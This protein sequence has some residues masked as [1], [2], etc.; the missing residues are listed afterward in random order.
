MAAADQKKL[1]Q[2]TLS[3]PRGTSSPSKPAG[4]A[5]STLRIAPSEVALNP[6]DMFRRPESS[7]TESQ[8]ASFSLPQALEQSLAKQGTQ[9]DMKLH[10]LVGQ[11]LQQKEAMIKVL[12]DQLD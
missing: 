4:S 6:H 11:A 1:K 2:A 5:K 7:K 12:E 3:P 8:E 10:H 9:I